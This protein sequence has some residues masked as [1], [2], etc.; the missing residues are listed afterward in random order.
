[1]VLD[2]CTNLVG[3]GG[4]GVTGYNRYFMPPLVWICQWNSVDTGLETAWGTSGCSAAM[5]VRLNI[6]VTCKL[7]FC[8]STIMSAT[9]FRGVIK[10]QRTSGPSPR[11][12]ASFGFLWV[13][14]SHPP[15]LPHSHSQSIT[16]SFTQTLT[17]HSNTHSLRH[18][19]IQWLTHSAKCMG[20]TLGPQTEIEIWLVYNNN[21]TINRIT[22]TS[23]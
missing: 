3:G 16:P 10:Q 12:M 19:L 2:A 15:S 1:M 21:T 11:R 9:K 18:F 7:W 5:F 6:S 8:I 14:N 20:R 4:G 13:S 22:G 23:K 17:A